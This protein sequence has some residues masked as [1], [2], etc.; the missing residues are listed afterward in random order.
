VGLLA[1]P[2]ALFAQR[3]RQSVQSRH[4]AGDRLTESRHVQRREVV[5]LDAVLGRETVEVAPCDAHDSLVGQPEVVQHHR[6][7]VTA[8]RLVREL[9]LRQ[10]PVGVALRDEK[11]A[12]LAR[13]GLRELV[14]I[15][16]FHRRVD[17]VD[18]EAQPREIQETHRG[19]HAYFDALICAQSAHAVFE[20]SGRAGYGVQRRA[21]AQCGGRNSLGNRGVHLGERVVALVFVVERDRIADERSA[22]VVTRAKESALCRCDGVEGLSC[23]ETGG[24]G[25]QPD[26][27]DEWTC[28]VTPTARRRCPRADP[29][30]RSARRR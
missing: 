16:Q 20:H 9:H 24:A 26:D 8:G 19:K 4:L 7:L 27:R 17:R 2:R 18:A 5:G 25:P 21:V 14:R 15:H 30:V 23:H 29:S 13:R 3:A 12:S 22:R 1:I 6:S 10:H 28:H 11:R